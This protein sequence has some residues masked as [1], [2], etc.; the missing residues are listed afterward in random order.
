MTRNRHSLHGDLWGEMQVMTLPVIHLF[1]T[2]QPI[3]VTGKPTLPS[4]I[5]LAGSA[6]PFIKDTKKN[7]HWIK[8]LE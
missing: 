1:L 4:P 3:M 7:I 2:L 6:H 8:D 5:C